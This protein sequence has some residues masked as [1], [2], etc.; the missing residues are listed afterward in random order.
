[1]SRTPVVEPGDVYEL[2]LGHDGLLGY[3]QC[4]YEVAPGWLL[5]ALEFTTQQRPTALQAVVDGPE[6][7]HFHLV[8]VG[9]GDPEFRLA[10]TTRSLR[11]PA[12]SSPCGNGT[13]QGLRAASRGVC[14]WSTARRSWTS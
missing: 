3:A 5:R 13:A 6:L 2:D 14:S 1:M 9:L 4:L 12:D 10:A 7:F 8:T 11:T